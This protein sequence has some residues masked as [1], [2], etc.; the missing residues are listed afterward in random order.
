VLG[1][2]P[3]NKTQ[4][5]VD[6]SKSKQL[7]HFL[8][9][10]STES[11]AQYTAD[12]SNPIHDPSSNFLQTVEPPAPIM[13]PPA[14]PK[15]HS[16]AASYPSTA[17][18]INVAARNAAMVSQRQQMLDRQF[19]QPQRLPYSTSNMGHAIV[20]PQPS[21]DQRQI[22]V[23]Q[24]QKA[25]QLDMQERP[26]GTS[27]TQAPGSGI[28]VDMQAVERQRQFQFHAAQQSRNYNDWRGRISMPA[29]YNY[30]GLP[31]IQNQASATSTSVTP[32]SNYTQYASPHHSQSPIQNYYPPPTPSSAMQPVQAAR[33]SPQHHVG[34]PA[35]LP[36]A[37]DEKYSQVSQSN[38]IVHRMDPVGAY[39]D[40]IRIQ[41]ERARIEQVR[42][43]ANQH[44][45]DGFQHERRLS[46]SASFPFK[47]PEE[48]KARKEERE[49]N[50]SPSSRPGSNY[51]PDC[52]PTIKTEQLPSYPYHDLQQ[53][54]SHIQHQSE[55]HH[56]PS[57][58]DPNATQ[59]SPP[60]SNA[61]P[62]STMM[63]PPAAPFCKPSMSINTPPS[64]LR[65]AHDPTE[66]MGSQQ[67]PGMQQPSAE[68][69][70]ALG[71]PPLLPGGKEVK[72]MLVP[73]VYR[74]W[75]EAGG[76]LGGVADYFA[77][78]RRAS[79]TVYKSPYAGE[80]G[81]Q[82]DR[83]DGRELALDFY[84]RLG[85]EDRAKI[86]AVRNGHRLGPEAEIET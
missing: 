42:A 82:E 53:Q 19:S 6:F 3:K 12:P 15:R 11:K 50:Q 75:S 85:E 31:P 63:G 39:E 2:S 47:P 73:A 61:Y 36:I 60:M 84:N 23:R 58:V 18:N 13:A 30:Q 29:L 27:Q 44:P 86:D 65:H 26:Y 79:P 21:L 81:V 4:K 77:R 35:P 57:F 22:L 5:Q 25:Q 46:G 54:H 20:R 72:N 62:P 76:C 43:V 10:T 41:N 69:L 48:L 70:A 7:W 40:R 55:G 9:Q 67:Q 66:A 52:S 71:P 33:Q 74:T 17:P 34:S 14:P 68:L 49:A 80:D 37:H 64:E 16:L 24:H 78:S 51:M 1:V 8:G 83:K 56:P 28:G 38:Q 45:D 59:L 32:Y